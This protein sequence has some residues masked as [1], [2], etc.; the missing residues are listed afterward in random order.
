MARKQIKVSKRMLFTC[1]MLG[2]LIFLFAPQGLTSKFQFAFARTFSWPLGIGRSV[3]LA[4]RTP[5]STEF[6][7]RREY[8]RLQNHLANVIQQRDQAYQQIKKLSALGSRF[9]FEDAKWVLADIITGSIDESRHEFIINRGAEDGLAKGQFVLGDNS[10]IGT[11]SETGARRAK[12]R[13]FT[14][15]A[16]NIAVKIA[17]LNV[18]RLMQGTGNNSAK[19][20]LLQV[21]HKVKT[22]DTVYACKKP[23]FLD[24]PMIIGKVRRCKRDDE[25]PSLWDIT[26]KPVCD[27]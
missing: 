26:V 13:L 9:P 19:I 3:T 27:I 24:A 23:G 5:A 10:I 20:R 14:D 7:S 2:G 1:F 22:G 25:N 8:D 15:P 17:G 18:S 16:S 11:I 4:A 12:V 21:M 6:V